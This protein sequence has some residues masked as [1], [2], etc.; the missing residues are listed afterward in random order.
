MEFRQIIKH[1]LTMHAV[2]SRLVVGM[3]V[4]DLGSSDK[5]SSAADDLDMCCHPPS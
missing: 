4:L 3:S 1:R 2:A 5:P